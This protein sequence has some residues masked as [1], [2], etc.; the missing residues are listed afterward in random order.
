MELELRADLGYNTLSAWV[1]GTL[2]HTID[3]AGD[4]NNGLSDPQ[5]MADKFNYAMFGFHSFSGNSADVW[6]DDVTLSTS[7]QTCP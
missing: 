3:E 7:R 4:W 2:V 5:W 6:M 1:D